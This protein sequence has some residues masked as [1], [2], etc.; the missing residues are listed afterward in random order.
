MGTK[1]DPGQF[2]CYAN[3]EADEPMFVLLARDPA[4]PE[5]VEAWAN[6][7]LVMIHD[8]LKPDSDR[9]MIQEARECADKMRAW[10]RA[11]RPIGAADKASDVSEPVNQSNAPQ[12]VQEGE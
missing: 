12:P 4:A 6:R 3:A 10:R 9:S 2:D 7:R 8:G 1:N 5:L 11:N